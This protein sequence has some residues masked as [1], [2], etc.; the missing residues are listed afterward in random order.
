MLTS[1]SLRQLL[2]TAQPKVKV[3]SAYLD[4]NAATGL[5]KDKLHAWHAE[6][7]RLGEA[8][9]DPQQHR[10]FKAD[11]AVLD[12]FLKDHKAQ[13]A[14]LVVFSSAAQHLWWVA[15]L[16]ASLP[17]AFRYEDGPYVGPAEA[18]LADQES[19][20]VVLL[21][22]EQ[23]RLLTVSLGEVGE[24]RHVQT[25]V[26][27][28]QHQRPDFDPRLEH[29]REEHDLAH[30]RAVITAVQTLHQETR[31]HRLILG[32]TDEPVALLQTHLPKPLSALVAGTFRAAL[33]ATNAQVLVDA[34][35]VEAAFDQS[36]DARTVEEL[37]TR[38]SKHKHAVLGADETLL[39]LRHGNAFELVIAGGYQQAGCIC[40]NCGYAAATLVRL[41]PLCTM[42]TQPSPDIV[43]E[44]V[45][46][47]AARGLHI[48]VITGLA[49]EQLVGAGSMGAFLKPES[50]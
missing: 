8:Q 33:H 26:A 16:R 38:G 50:H 3:L 15:P 30:V 25:P 2:E 4:T 7:N 24:Q 20:C 34:A 36:K 46:K 6:L 29:R 5:W 28:L 11:R 45:K 49:R 27:K 37:V 18:L 9:T 17:Q 21:D 19:Y 48:A 12:T 32:G 44:A 47:A 13:G 43:E 22:H 14:T 1:Q 40:P 35:K 39:A 41:C 23:A 31:F 42:P 10:Q